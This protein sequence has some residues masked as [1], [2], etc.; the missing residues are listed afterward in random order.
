VE[1]KKKST[2]NFVWIAAIGVFVIVF[3]VGIFGSGSSNNTNFNP[4]PA[5]I[6]GNNVPE[7]TQPP[8]NPITKD[9]LDVSALI[10]QTIN[11][12]VQKIKSSS[13]ASCG[14]YPCI[15]T[16]FDSG[17]GVVTLIYEFSADSLT[18]GSKESLVVEIITK[19]Y[20]DENGNPYLD[21]KGNEIPKN[22]ILPD[23]FQF[24]DTDFDAMPN[25][26]WSTSFGQNMNFEI[27]TRN[28]RD[29]TNL[30]SIWTFAINYFNQN[31]LK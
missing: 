22:D 6:L 31:L 10:P 14:G 9:Q 19:T 7:G 20:L 5:P 8:N 18:P 3:L 4:S 21:E 1:N 13:N 17:I 23:V 16:T 15:K 11:K 29:L 2:P 24:R 28:T 25:D 12:I 26:Y 30:W 27:I